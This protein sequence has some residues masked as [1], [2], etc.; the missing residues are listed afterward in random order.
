VNVMDSYK[1]T[2][3]KMSDVDVVA[4]LM[5]LRKTNR[6]SVLTFESDA[7][8]LGEMMEI[9]YEEVF[10]NRVISRKLLEPMTRWAVNDAP[11]Y[12]RDLATAMRIIAAEEENDTFVDATF[13]DKCRRE[14]E[15][16]DGIAISLRTSLS[17]TSSGRTREVRRRTLTLSPQETQNSGPSWI[18]VLCVQGVAES[19]F[20]PRKHP[21]KVQRPGNPEGFK[22]NGTGGPV[23]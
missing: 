13:T 15:R 5:D 4:E 9:V 7:D 20:E 2:I 23:G 8:T 19:P 6:R 1:A 21:R 12:Y 10:E 16:L 11:Q 3:R 17:C 22:G 18:G 14:A